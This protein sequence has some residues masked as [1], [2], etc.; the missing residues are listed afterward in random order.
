MT[1]RIKAV[2]FDLDGVLTDTAELHYLGWQ[3]LADEEGLTF[4]REENEKLRGLS[5]RDSMIAILKHQQSKKQQIEKQQID[6]AVMQ[7]WMDRKNSYYQDS[8]QTLSP[9]DLLPG[10]KALLDQAKVAG[11]KLAVASASYNA[12]TVLKRLKIASY[13]DVIVAGP[14]PKAGPGKSRPK[15][16]PDPFLLAAQKLNLSPAQCVVVEDAASGIAA[17]R[18]GGM[19]T[20]GLGP[21]ARVGAADRVFASLKGVTLADILHAATMQVAEEN[22]SA[23]S[24]WHWETVFT[25]G[26]GYLG[27]RGSLEEHF[28]DDK[29]MTLIH[30]L[31]DDMPI[32]YSELANAFDW[33]CVDLWID[34]QI[35]C[36]DKGTVSDYARTLDLRDGVLYR[37]FQWKAKGGS[38]VE[39][40]LSRFASLADVNALAL[41][42]T[43]TALDKAVS[44][45][46]RA[47]LNGHVE[48][49]GTP[50][51]WRGLE[52][53]VDGDSVTLSG[54][55]RKTDK[56]LVEAMRLQ[57]DVGGQTSAAR[58]NDAPAN[59]GWEC[60]TTVQP[61]QTLQADKLVSWYIDRDAKDPLAA[62]KKKVAQMAVAGYDKLHAANR[63]AWA[64]FWRESEV[65]I[66]GDDEAQLSVRH[67]L[68]QMRIAAP[69]RDINASI[70]ARS[71]SGFGYRGHVFWDTESYTLPFFTFA[72]P[73]LARN[74][75]MYRYHTL[76]GARRKA[77]GNGYAGAQ[78]SWES[79]ETGDEVTPT[80]VPSFDGK[81]LVRIWCGD[82]ELH[83]SVDVSY[84]IHQYWRV[85]GDD[86]FMI[87]YGAPIFLE[88]ALFWASRAEPDK[89]SQ[90]KYSISDVIGP[91]EYHDHVNNNAYTNRMVRWHLETAQ[92]VL[93][94]IKKQDP[95]RHT[96]LVKQYDL[97]AK[98]LKKWQEIAENLVFHYDEQTGLIEQCDN[99]FKL[100]EVDWPKYEGRNKSMQFLLG[101]EGANEHQV[102]KQPDVIFLLCLLAD[103]F[104]HKT[105]Q[106]NWDYYSPRTDHQYGS[107]LGP[108]M[109]AWMAC[110]MS[111]P[112]EGYEHFMRAARADLGDVRGNAHEG[113][114]VASAGGLWQAL[115]FGFAGLRIHDDGSFTTKARL[116]SHWQRLK[117]V[118]TLRGKRQVIDI[119]K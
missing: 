89:P 91:D 55:T 54:F 80:W 60:E 111:K 90:G 117:F 96:E 11:L 116:P 38:P 73:K 61:N 84:G 46:L 50:A 114:H 100:K 51:H 53:A 25:I 8:L 5:R 102:L 64:N 98:R 101:I 93:G 68:F 39:I 94:W 41:R 75:L 47:R 66:E 29:P 107:S 103:H 33:T 113:I 87:T 15:P 44:V 19:T 9:K 56:Q 57:V 26:N 35:V 105:L 71:L 65:T 59:P 30:G 45:R 28:P 69:D 85:T 119:K 2:L 92:Q 22:F 112:D 43:V 95:A 21:V 110:E 17:G 13:F 78:Y 82:I 108:A 6:E 49:E 20:V 24:Q 76:A 118:F 37:R 12:P 86:E 36:M 70:G 62:A 63:R 7:A 40:T 97:N 42:V 67:A 3:R 31:W 18:A 58:Y 115:A 72:Q 23:N 14:D 16:A 48:N 34:G 52:Q 109:H 10:V 83:I 79:A 104:P 4:D 74:L 32:S 99:F 27:T 106:T 88:T 77:K 81:N 1:T